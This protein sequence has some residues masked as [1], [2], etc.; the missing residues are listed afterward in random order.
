M[1]TFF[2]LLVAFNS[3]LSHLQD[4]SALLCSASK[5]YHFIIRS[6]PSNPAEVSGNIQNIYFNS[7]SSGQRRPKIDLESGICLLCSVNISPLLQLLAR[8]ELSLSLSLTDIVDSLANS[9]SMEGSKELSRKQ[10]TRRLC[11]D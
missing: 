1:E 8:R 2:L 4:L 3:K 5:S 7:G 10:K 9:F 11:L 6:I